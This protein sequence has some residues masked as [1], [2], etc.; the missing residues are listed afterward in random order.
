MS[1]DDYFFD[2]QGGPLP[3]GAQHLVEVITKGLTAAFVVFFSASEVVAE[4]RKLRDA[5]R[6]STGGPIP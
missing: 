3:P 5:Q 2:V 4:Y 6:A 1:A